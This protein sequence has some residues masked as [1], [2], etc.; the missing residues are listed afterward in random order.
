MSDPNK[1]NLLYFEALSMRGLHERME[2]WQNENQKR[3]LSVSIERDNGKVCCIALTNPTEVIIVDGTS[4]DG[5]EVSGYRLFV[6]PK[7]N[8]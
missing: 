5:A 2:E 3:F 7:L 4:S 8:K 6:D 1:Q